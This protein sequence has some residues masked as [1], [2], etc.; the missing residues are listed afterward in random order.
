MFKKVFGDRIEQLINWQ[1]KRHVNEALTRNIRKHG[2]M[3]LMHKKSIYYNPYFCTFITRV[4]L[5]CLVP[6]VLMEPYVEY[7]VSRLISEGV[8]EPLFSRFVTKKYSGTFNEQFCF[9]ERIINSKSL[10]YKVV[11][12]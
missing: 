5:L 11:L 8:E 6:L 9:Y 10:R 3:R 4:K 12:L 1:C 7:L 2:L